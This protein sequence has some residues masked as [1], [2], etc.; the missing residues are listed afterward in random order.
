MRPYRFS[1]THSKVISS[2]AVAAA[3]GVLALPAAAAGAPPPN[4]NRGNAQTIGVPATVDGATAESTLEPIEP[5]GCDQSRGSVWYVYTADRDRPV[6]ADLTANGDLDGALEV[7]RV[8]R[9]QL[10]SL[11][12]DSSDANGRASVAFDAERGQRYLF[13]VTQRQNSVAG[14]FQLRTLVV[15]RPARPPGATL[16]AAGVSNS[17]NRTLNPSDAWSIR[18]RE[19]V[20]YRFNVAA[21]TCVRFELFPPGTRSFSSR[22]VRESTCGGYM[23]F[24]PPP[25]RGGRYSIRI[26]MQERGAAGYRLTAARATR[27]DTIPGIPLLNYDPETGALNGRRIDVVDLYRFTIDRSS[28]LQLDLRTKGKFDLELRNT[29]GRILRCMCR[30]EGSVQLRTR[31]ARGRYFAVVRAREMST[32]SYKLTRI[33]RAT[34]RTQVTVSNPRVQPGATVTIAVQ[35]S[36]GATGTTLVGVERFDPEFGWQFHARYSVRA[37]AGRAT[38]A[39]RTP[40]AA[41][42]RVRA[43]YLGSRNLGPS[44]SFFREFEA[45]DPIGP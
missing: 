7:F 2:G 42:F 35:I 20:T 8:R 24:T 29:R 23:L 12:C 22:A 19:G 28:G 39:F 14:T 15:Q 17:V 44:S 1:Y 36:G 5:S 3:V 43:R 38:L 31:I 16:P 25:D 11:D 40:F 33:T 21:R 41:R 30:K 9:S 18:L 45:A 10:T 34:T 27:D 26:S 4:D 6:V 13:R 32:S 37:T